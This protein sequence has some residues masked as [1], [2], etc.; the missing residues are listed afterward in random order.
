M[1]KDFRPVLGILLRFIIMYVVL[2]FA[3]QMY[4]NSFA[5][6]GLDPL[7]RRVAGQ[8]MHIQ[9]ALHYPTQLYDD[10]KREQVWFYVQ[11]QYTSRMVEGC[12]AVSVMILFV[13]F[14]FAFFKGAKTFVFVVAGLI[15]LYIMNLL[16]I[17]GLNIVV[18]DYK[19]YSKATH[20]FIFPAVIYGTVVTL[21]LVW[22]K[23][24]ALKNENS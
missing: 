1:L 7:S 12:N 24:F 19:E 17:V 16:R 10:V 6:S 5:G 11:K 20:D 14:V 18:I 21:W 8:V 2:L 23:F 9:N 22:I 15:I 13:A 3:Y 4:L